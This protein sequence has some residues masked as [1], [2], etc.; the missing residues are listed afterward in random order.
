MFG[1]ILSALNA[2]LAFFVKS[3]VLKG[4]TLLVLFSITSSFVPVLV[5]LLPNT[6]GLINAFSF[7]TP[8]MWY[9]LQPF[10]IGSG[11]TIIFN[12][13]GLRFIIHRL[14]VIG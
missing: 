13:Y 9:W 11:L 3:T 10:Q 8:D 5:G 6:N 12:A 4:I 1:I 7:I 14:P 2:A